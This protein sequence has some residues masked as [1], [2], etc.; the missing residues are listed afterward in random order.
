MRARSDRRV[1]RK[2]GKGL[3]KWANIKNLLSSFHKE[4]IEFLWHTFIKTASKSRQQITK[5]FS[6]ITR[7]AIDG[8]PERR[9]YHEK[10]G[11][12]RSLDLAFVSGKRIVNKSLSKLWLLFWQDWLKVSCFFPNCNVV[13]SPNDR[14]TKP[15]PLCLCSFWEL[16]VKKPWLYLIGSGV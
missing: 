8:K 2:P 13:Q 9:R 12:L 16:Y 14:W 1:I 15:R 4:M 10:V 3:I 7:V 6:T 11:R 5:S